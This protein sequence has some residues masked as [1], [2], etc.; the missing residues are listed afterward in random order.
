M[1]LTHVVGAGLSGLS[2]AV[3]LAEA[4]AQVTV[5]EAA[6]HAGGR[7]RSFFDDTLGCEI[8]NGNHLLLSGNWA[9][10]GLLRTVGAE[11]T[12]LRAPEAAFPFIDFTTGER[13]TVRPGPGRWPGWLFDPARRVADSRPHEYLRAL[14]LAAAGERTVAAC[15]DTERPIYRRFWE[16]LTV[17]VLNT[18]AR[19]ASARLL[20]P[21]IRETFGRGE[22]ASRP[23]IARDGLSRTF[24]DP[25]LAYLEKRG[26]DVRFGTRLRA[27]RIKDDRAE[28]MDFSTGEIELG[29]EDT[30]VLAVPAA[31]AQALLPGIEAPRESRPIVN[32]HFRANPSLPDASN[33]RLFF[34]GMIGGDADWLFLRNGV[35][36]ITVSAA[37]DLVDLPADEISRRLWRDA[38][39]ALEISPDPIPPCRI[40]KEKRAT[41]AQTP[42]E[43]RRRSGTRG[44]W[45][46]LFLAGDWTDT[47]LPATIEGSVRSGEAAAR[48][49]L[50]NI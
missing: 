20:W 8:D 5:H 50:E 33:G 43:A 17:A 13:W 44:P 19:E 30:L 21:V 49:V 38:A 2:C 40:V 22:P 36:S 9:A 35:I 11:D 12:L 10:M 34:V 41:F 37:E 31:G 25:T 42:V 29:P 1:G 3:R 28:A 14:A 48:A 23:C 15:F 26:A 4:G 47:G 16:P 45:R 6:G 24:I 18:A 32:A 39:R 27:L 7:C 46:N